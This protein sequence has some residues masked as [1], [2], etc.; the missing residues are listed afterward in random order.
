MTASADVYK[1]VGED[2][3]VYYSDKQP[4]DIECEKIEIEH[5]DP[6]KCAEIAESRRRLEEAEKQADQR[7]EE[8]RKKLAAEQSGREARLAKQQQCHEARKQ[9]VILQTQIPVYRDT[10]G[11]IRAAW[12]YD[13][14][15]GEREYLDDA[16]RAAEIKSTKKLI[17]ANCQ[18]ADDREA[19]AQ[20]R[21]RWIRSE[22]C[23]AARSQLQA[24]KRPQAKSTDQAIEDKQR[25]VD[26]YCED[27]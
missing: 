1:W 16:A 15:K 17:A 14:Y 6:D 13:T 9:L 25:E 24:M 2:G 4:Q 7:I 22:R 20:A 5:R 8:R 11:R 12:M 27:E 21:K 19:Q 18:N 10:E 26:L 23:A 3:R